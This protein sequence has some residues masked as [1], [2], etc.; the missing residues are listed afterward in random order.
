[1]AM[2][3]SPASKAALEWRRETLHEI[4]VQEMLR[5]ALVLNLTA[6][7]AGAPVFGRPN[8]RNIQAI[9]RRVKHCVSAPIAGSGIGATLESNLARHVLR[10]AGQVSRGLVNPGLK[11][12]RFASGLANPKISRHIGNKCQHSVEFDLDAPSA[13]LIHNCSG[14]PQAGSVGG[15]GGVVSAPI[16]RAAYPSRLLRQAAANHQPGWQPMTDRRPGFNFP[17]AMAGSLSSSQKTYADSP[18]SGNIAGCPLRF[19]LIGIRVPGVA[20]G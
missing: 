8:F 20:V 11:S 12:M 15:K 7:I 1:M 6:V 9:S 2:A 4:A 13:S 19:F 3:Y 10:Q 5:L 18:V 14:K 16:G 17:M